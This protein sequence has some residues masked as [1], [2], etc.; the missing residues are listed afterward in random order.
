MAHDAPFLQSV[1]SEASDSP[2]VL[3]K[4]PARHG[5]CADDPPGQKWPPVQYLHAVE[6]RLSWYVPD[7]QLVQVCDPLNALTVPGAHGVCAVDPVE[8]KLPAGQMVHA[9]ALPRPGLLE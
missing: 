5:S 9:D 1:Q 2:D 6:P 3:E 4:V 7:R 8:Q